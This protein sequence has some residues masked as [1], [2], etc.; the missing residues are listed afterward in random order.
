MFSLGTWMR[1]ATGHPKWKFRGA[2]QDRASKGSPHPGLLTSH[3]GN[4]QWLS[5]SG[6]HPCGEIWQSPAGL[7]TIPGA[8]SGTGSPGE[9]KQDRE[10]KQL[11]GLM[12]KQDPNILISAFLSFDGFAPLLL[13]SPFMGDHSHVLIFSQSLY[14]DEEGITTMACQFH[15]HLISRFG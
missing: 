10:V 1:S 8:R 7:R 3:P 5:C 9:E 2:R 14:I 12:R 11:C 15:F 6:L 4:P 13:P